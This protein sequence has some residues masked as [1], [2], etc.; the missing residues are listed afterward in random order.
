ML[1]QYITQVQRLL[2]DLSAQFWSVAELTDYIN[3]ARNRVAQDTKCLRQLVTGIPL[4]TQQEAYSPQTFLN[5]SSFIGANLVTVMGITVYQSATNRIKLTYL[6]FSRF[7]AWIRPFT[8]NFN[9]PTNWTRVGSNMVYVG[10][11]PDQP[12]TTDWD[13]AVIPPPLVVDATPEAIPVPFQEP[14]QYYAAYKAKWK[15]QAQGEAKI[16]LDQYIQMVRWSARSFVTW[17]T[18]SSYRTG[19]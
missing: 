4:I 19:R 7:D 9:T 12:Y 1:N 13:V 10:L 2:H 11:P 5:S 18:P 17:I 6:P 16:F 8:N 14:V 15:E 3:E